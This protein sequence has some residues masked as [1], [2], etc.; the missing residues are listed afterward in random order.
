MSD[1]T[2]NFSEWAI[3]DLFGHQRIAGQVSNQNI[4]SATFVRVD[5][6]ED[7]NK[8][9]FTRFFNPSAIYGI[10]PVSKKVALAAAK[11]IDAK[12]VQAWD[13]PAPPAQRSLL[14]TRSYDDEN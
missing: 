14:A 4:G 1:P 8:V 10:S 9:A 11:A 5:V 6:Y 2:D 7:S 12:P 13:M 3:V